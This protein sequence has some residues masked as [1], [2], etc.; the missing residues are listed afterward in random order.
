MNWLTDPNAPLGKGNA[1]MD[2]ARVGIETG[3]DYEDCRY[4]LGTPA[5]NIPVMLPPSYRK[6]AADPR[7]G[8]PDGHLWKQKLPEW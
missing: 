7:V 2:Q 3:Q 5:D 6:L 1:G 4:L 8:L